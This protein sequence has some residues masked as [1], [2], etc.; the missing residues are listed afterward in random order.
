M[1]E[2]NHADAVSLTRQSFYDTAESGLFLLE[3]FKGIIRKCIKGHIPILEQ[4]ILSFKS[5]F[6]DK[7]SSTK[8]F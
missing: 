3:A 7:V 1:L 8:L 2:K 5:F 4:K 6:L